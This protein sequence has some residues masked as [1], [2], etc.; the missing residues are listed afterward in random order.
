ME[1]TAPIAPRAMNERIKSVVSMGP[2]F[3]V[4]GRFVGLQPVRRLALLLRQRFG[5]GLKPGRARIG[6]LSPGSHA[7]RSHS[8]PM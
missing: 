7:R 2:V 4:L 1:A 6:V 3:V 5:A 8:L